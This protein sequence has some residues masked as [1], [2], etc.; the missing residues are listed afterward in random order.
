M[1][2]VDIRYVITPDRLAYVTLLDTGRKFVV[3]APYFRKVLG[4]N[5]RTVLGSTTLNP[6]ELRALGVLP[7]KEVTSDVRTPIAAS[8][9]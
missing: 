5:P 6:T 4:L 1:K 7:A 8:A 3:Q 9:V 2:S